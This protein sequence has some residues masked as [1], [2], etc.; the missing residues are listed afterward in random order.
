M[1][2]EDEGVPHYYKHSKICFLSN[3]PPKECGIATFTKDLVNAM[4][5]SY[6]A[7]LKSQVIALNEE[8]DFYNYDHRVVMQI[9]KEDI[10]D[11]IIKAKEINKS[12][13]IKIVSIQHEFGIFGGEHGSYLIP[14][15]E[16]IEK[17]VVI[18][19]HSVLPNPDKKR[20]K[21]VKF[22]GDKSAKIIVMANSAIK[23]LN[24]EYDIPLEKIQLVH[25]GIP[26]TSLLP[27]ASFKKKLRLENK[28]VLSTFG[29][30]SRGKGFEYIIKSLPNL[31]KKYPNIIYLIIGETHPVIRRQE[32][33]KYRNELLQLVNELGLK[34]HVK[35]YNKYS[36]LPELIQNILATDI[37]I[38][39]NLDP[40][41]I[42]SGTLSY[43]LGCG[44]AIISTPSIYA[45]EILSN[46]RGLL[47]IFKDPD[48]YENAIN[49]ILSN[50][51]LKSKLEKNAYFFGRSMSWPNVASKYLNIFNNITNL[52]E[53]TIEYLPQ[54][55]LN[56]LRKLT[57]NFGCIQ[58]S[59]LSNPEKKSGYTV[60]D[61][62]RALIAAT[63][64]YNLFKSHQSLT[65]IKIYLKFLERAQA[66]N[67]HFLNNFLNENE[68]LDPC[69][70]DAIG[71]AVWALGYLIH[72]CEIEE[73]VTKAKEMFTISY[74]LLEK[75]TQLRARA[76]AIIG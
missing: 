40:D 65:L 18:T 3:F 76:F 7:K 74:R 37:Y 19:F 61:N 38:C 32:G 14:F 35:F 48:S 56:Y 60:D 33:E 20:K 63:N 51:T 39:T 10:E 30:I 4:D 69:S 57:D 26:N 29:L 47:T 24:E 50:P 75:L 67:G 53:K 11:Y 6:N 58:F 36:T 15:L 34:N 54:I 73:I 64:H 1:I 59:N 23:I 49:Q 62:A 22:L 44:K 28:I 55:K 72:K 52:K 41:Q 68:L 71:R 9:N 16:T 17:P 70:E 66:K 25:H 13:K 21:I 45:K 5:K 43:A 27:T 8:T 2:D 46:E 31:V 12:N 42:V